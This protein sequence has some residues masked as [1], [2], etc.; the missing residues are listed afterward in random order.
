MPLPWMLGPMIG[1]TIAA[2]VHLPIR[3]PVRLRPIVIPI[4]GVMLGSA[5][6]P[7]ILGQ[8]TSWLVTLVLLAPFIAVAGLASFLFYSRVAGYDRITAFYCAA[9]GG[10]NEMVILGAAAGGVERQIALAHSARILVVVTAVVWFYNAGLG[11]QSGDIARPTVALGALS[12]L[13]M[14]LL[15]GSAILGPAFARAVRLPAAGMLGPM[16]LSAAA[17]LAG[18]VDVPPPA[19][20]VI[21]AQ[22]VIG[23]VIGCRFAGTP[24]REIL[25]DVGL[26]IGSSTVMLAVALGFA[27]ALTALTGTDLAQSF[28]AFSPGGL[29]E[30]SLLALAMGQDVA[31]VSFAHVARIV[32]VIAAAP[33]AARLGGFSSPS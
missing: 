15:A 16:V 1:N 24:A 5:F 6:S 21:V 13:D 14:A 19:P 22:I 33:I 17:H 31:Y 4:I 20:L 23:T 29:T 11:V 28:L 2:L 27:A 26:G 10:L 32:Y 7:A 30:M 9:P 3:G 12:L 18:W 8:I 25:R